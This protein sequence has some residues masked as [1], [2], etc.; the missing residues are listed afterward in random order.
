MGFQTWGQ[1][2]SERGQL[3]VDGA[4]YANSTSPT[5][6]SPAPLLVLPANYLDVGSVIRCTAWGEFSTTG[7]PTLTLGIYYGGVAGTA[8]ATTG[9]VTTQ[10]AASH[11]SFRLTFEFVCRTI[12]TSGTVYGMGQL[13]GVGATPTGGT[14]GTT[15]PVMLPANTPAAVTVDTTT[16]KALT[17]GATWGAASASNTLTVHGYLVES[18]N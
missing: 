16:A 14:T 17:V 18:L 11:A 2:I 12:G 1:L 10:S 15:T 8:I 9:A 4:A 3:A 5:D 13:A 7:T 6:V